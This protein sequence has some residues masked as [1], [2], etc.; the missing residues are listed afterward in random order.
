MAILVDRQGHMVSDSSLSEL[1]AFASFVGLQRAWFQ[2]K[3]IP[4]Y[5]LTS[6]NMKNKAQRGGA[7]LVKSRELVKRAVRNGEYVRKPT[8][9]AK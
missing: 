3:R 4:H 7:E 6:E 2:N 9:Y 5:D 8:M 1:H